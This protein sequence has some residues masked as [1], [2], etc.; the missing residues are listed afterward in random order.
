MTTKSTDILTTSSSSI[1][2][3]DR[4]IKFQCH[5]NM[6]S[7]PIHIKQ[8]SHTHTHARTPKPNQMKI[9]GRRKIKQKI[10]QQHF[11]K[12][13][14][15]TCLHSFPFSVFLYTYIYFIFFFFIYFVGFNIILLWFNRNLNLKRIFIS[16]A[17]LTV[18][19]SIL[20]VRG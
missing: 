7:H 15:S 1:N 3:N 2:N 12:H 10:I 14:C 17:L 13:R 4:N 19:L 18:S 9:N 8:L 20:K 5:L 6:F 16:D 11:D